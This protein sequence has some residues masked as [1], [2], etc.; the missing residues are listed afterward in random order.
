[1]YLL[2]QFGADKELRER[3]PDYIDSELIRRIKGLDKNAE[4]YE[5]LYEI[6]RRGQV[7]LELYG[8]KIKEVQ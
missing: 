6:Y 7:F 5:T 1:M 3:L 2:D 8:D 4:S